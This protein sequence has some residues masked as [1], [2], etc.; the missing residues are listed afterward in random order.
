VSSAD[1]HDVNGNRPGNRESASLRQQ[2][3]R[4]HQR[5]RDHLLRLRRQSL[6]GLFRAPGPISA[7]PRALHV[8]RGPRGVSAAPSRGLPDGGDQAVLGQVLLGQI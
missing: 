2:R 3:R 8:A 4:L 6:S 5:V 1:S 7:A